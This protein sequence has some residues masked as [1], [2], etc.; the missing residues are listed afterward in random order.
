MEHAKIEVTIKT[1]N[2]ELAVMDCLSQIMYNFG[3]SNPEQVRIADW[4]A[5]RYG[6]LN[7]R[8]KANK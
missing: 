8:E 7:D 5:A 6:M 1:D 3:L 4:F 2:N